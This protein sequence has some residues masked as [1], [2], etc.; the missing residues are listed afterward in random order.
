MSNVGLSIV[1]PSYGRDKEVDD[2]LLSISKADISVGYEVIIIDQNEDGKLD[3][4]VKKYEFDLPINHQKVQFKGLSKARN[5]GFELSRGK[6]I[7][8][9]DDDSQFIKNTVQEAFGVMKETKADCISGRLIE[10][11]TGKNAMVSFPA[12]R[13]ILGLD[14]LDNSFIEPAMFFKREFLEEYQFDENM[15]V[16]T[17][18]GAQE[19]YDI[20]YRALK[21]RKKIVYDPEIIYYHPMKKGDRVSDGAISRAFYYSCGL[22]YLCKKHQFKSKFYLR[23]LKITAILPVVALIKNREFKYFFVQWMGILIGYKYV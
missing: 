3:S 12:T 11:T 16:G 18:H 5:Y 8:F 9:P 2:L 22:G 1:I 6:I 19:G 20:V 21:D 13:R 15:G 17:L 14:N 23:F 4:I 7:C 10:K